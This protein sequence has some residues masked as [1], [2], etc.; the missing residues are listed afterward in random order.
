MPGFAPPCS[1][2][3]AMRNLEVHESMAFPSKD[4]LIIRI[5]GG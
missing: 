2:S 4:G 5:K 1:F 3:V